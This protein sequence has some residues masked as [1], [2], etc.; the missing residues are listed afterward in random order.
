MGGEE[1]QPALCMVGET[2]ADSMNEGG[3]LSVSFSLLF[4]SNLDILSAN[5]LSDR[6]EGFCVRVVHYV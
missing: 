3:Q 4:L 2:V 5:H 1:S 6:F